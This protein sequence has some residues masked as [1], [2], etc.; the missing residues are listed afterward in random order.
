MGILCKFF[1]A[2]LR[3]Y[4]RFDEP[5]NLYFLFDKK[6]T[7][8][9]KYIE[10]KAK[11]L[12]LFFTKQSGRLQC[13]NGA[14]LSEA[15]DKLVELLFGDGN[16]HRVPDDSVI[17]GV[18]TSE[19]VSQIKVR[20]GQE[21]FAENVKNNF[22]MQCCFPGCN[23]AERDFLIASHIARWADN[24]EKRGDISN[25]LCLCLMHDKAFEKG[26][27]SLDDELRVCMFG[28]KAA[29]EI[30]DKEILPAVGI[31]IKQGTIEPDRE[32]LREHRM[33]CRLLQYKKRMDNI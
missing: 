7:L 12:N 8:F 14:Y 3:G 29:S 4:V 20:V 10:Q 22:K 11:P 25:G 31:A 9:E 21:K 5:L 1:R 23:V 2:F 15:D 33:R 28:R 26:Y 17:Y 27:F 16:E 18:S 6:R 24:Q 32:A 30:F 19:I 13:L